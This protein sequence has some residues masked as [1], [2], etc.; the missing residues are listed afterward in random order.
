[1]VLLAG[2]GQAP[3]LLVLLLRQQ[4]SPGQAQPGLHGQVSLRG[5]VASCLG[6]LAGRCASACSWQVEGRGCVSQ[7]CVLT[8][9]SPWAGPGRCIYGLRSCRPGAWPRPRDWLASRPLPGE[10]GAEGG[11]QRRSLRPPQPGQVWGWCLEQLLRPPSPPLCT[12]AQVLTP[13]DLTDVPSTAL[14]PAPPTSCTR[15]ADMCVHTCV[16]PMFTRMA[17]QTWDSAAPVPAPTAFGSR[18]WVRGQ[19]WEHPQGVGSKVRV[20]QGPGGSQDSFGVTAGGTLGYTRGTLEPKEA[21]DPTRGSGSLPGGGSGFSR[22]A[23]GPEDLGAGGGL[24]AG[25]RGQGL[26]SGTDC[27][28]HPTRAPDAPIPDTAPSP[29]GHGRLPLG[30]EQHL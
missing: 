20:P 13:C 23:W 7:V 1:M 12:S 22:S 16:T 19:G 5:L 21:P 4:C 15:P 25:L 18:D 11:V 17:V 27:T 14:L 30:R 8:G 24:G 9:V 3:R 26:P 10:L 28:P 2:Q 29:C 6:G